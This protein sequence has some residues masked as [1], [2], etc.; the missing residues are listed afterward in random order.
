MKNTCTHPID[1][2]GA[3]LPSYV[4]EDEPYPGTYS[5]DSRLFSLDAGQEQRELTAEMCFKRGGK[6]LYASCRVGVPYFTA[7]DASKFGCYR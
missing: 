3:C 4:E 7:P 6:M 5:L 1:A 2:R